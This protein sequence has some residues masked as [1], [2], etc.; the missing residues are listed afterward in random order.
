MLPIYRTK[1]GPIP[2][3]VLYGDHPFRGRAELH[4]QWS[5]AARNR[6]R[7]MVRRIK[8][9]VQQ[10]KNSPRSTYVELI[11]DNVRQQVAGA[12]GTAP[13]SFRG[14]TG[15]CVHGVPCL[16]VMSRHRPQREGSFLH[17]LHAGH[18]TAYRRAL[19]SLS[20][21]NRTLVHPQAAFLRVRASRARLL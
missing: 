5:R 18:E 6:F 16:A 3:W 4:R 11:R 17:A 10:R 1:L 2:E 15:G 8:R 12:D 14:P 7:Q 13:L 9:R 19:G 21:I 20:P